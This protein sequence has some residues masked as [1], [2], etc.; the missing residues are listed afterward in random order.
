MRYLRSFL[1]LIICVCLGTQPLPAQW[2]SPSFLPDQL[3]IGLTSPKAISKFIKTNFEFVED[4]QLF[5]QVDYWQS[6]KEFW[7]RKAGDCEDF[8]LLAESLLKSIGYEAHTVSIYGPDGYA[9]TVAIFKDANRYHVMNEGRLYRFRAKS[10]P[11]AISR[12][13]H[14]WTWAAIAEQKGTRGWLKEKII[15]P[16]RLS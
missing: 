15:N 3:G 9:H 11:Q 13:H 4:R 10:L 8:A 2:M 14:N 6:P 12:I 5:G 1:F 16:A 7:E